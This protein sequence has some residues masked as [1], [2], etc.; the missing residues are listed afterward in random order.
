MPSPFKVQMLWLWG[1]IGQSLKGGRWIF[2]RDQDRSSN[3]SR[4]IRILLR[5][6]RREAACSIRTPTRSLKVIVLSIRDL[7]VVEI[8]QT[9]K[10]Y[11]VMFW[12]LREIIWWL[13]NHKTTTAWTENTCEW[14]QTETWH[15]TMH[16]SPLADLPNPR[17]RAIKMVRSPRSCP[18]A[19]TCLKSKKP[20]WIIEGWAN[21]ASI[22][23][24]MSLKRMPK[25][26]IIWNLWSGL[27][28]HHFQTTR[29]GASLSK[30]LRSLTSR[31][32]QN[33]V[34]QRMKNKSYYKWKGVSHSRIWSTISK[35]L[36]NWTWSLRWTKLFHHPKIPSMF[37]IKSILTKSKRRKRQLSP[38]L[39]SI[40]WMIWSFLRRSGNCRINGSWWRGA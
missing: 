12:S 13:L 21:A 31:S 1:R 39:R 34:S 3:L 32:T 40:T 9:L 24:I 38:R 25:V 17:V 28:V 20:W 5:E 14:A 37:A 35:T 33:Q 23:K 30:M 26:I 16:P 2:G 6:I 11:K 29:I 4:R 10:R 22:M 15:P 19:S 18:K 8:P 27:Q 7:W 36:K